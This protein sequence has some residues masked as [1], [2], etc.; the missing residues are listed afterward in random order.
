MLN[1]SSYL[2]YYYFINWTFYHFG[3]YYAL[4][5]TSNKSFSFFL[6]SNKLLNEKTK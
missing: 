5:L 1:I 3:Y 4:F 2:I 6:F